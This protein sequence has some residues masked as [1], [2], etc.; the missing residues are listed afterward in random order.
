MYMYMEEC[1]QSTKHMPRQITALFCQ[2]VSSL[3]RVSGE[4]HF[5]NNSGGDESALHMLSFAQAVLSRGLIMSF[6]GNTGRSAELNCDG[7]V[8]TKIA[9]S[10][11]TQVWGQYLYRES[12]RYP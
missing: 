12:A 1:A 8:V 7:L 10:L 3:V 2:I 4:L 5:V 11:L 6:E 9:P